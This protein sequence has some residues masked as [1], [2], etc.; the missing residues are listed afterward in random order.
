MLFNILLFF[1][2]SAFRVNEFRGKSEKYFHQVPEVS[3]R[4]SNYT[5]GFAKFDIEFIIKVLLAKNI[6]PRPLLIAL[7]ARTFPLILEFDIAPSMVPCGLQNI[8]NTCYLISILQILHITPG[9]RDA[10]SN[11]FRRRLMSQQPNRVLKAHIETMND[12]DVAIRRG[13]INVPSLAVE[14]AKSQFPRPQQHDAAEYLSFVLGEMTECSKI[15]TSKRSTTV[16]CERCPGSET[17]MPPNDG[18][19][20]VQLMDRQLSNSN[21]VADAVEMWH[22]ETNDYPTHIECNCVKSEKTE[23]HVFS[24]APDALAVAF[25]VVYAD[26]GGSKK[27]WDVEISEQ[28]FIEDTNDRY[29]LYAI[30]V[31]EDIGTAGGHYYAYVKKNK[32]WYKCNDSSVSFVSASETRA[33]FN[34]RHSPH[35]LF[36]AKDARQSVKEEPPRKKPKLRHS[37]VI[38]RSNVESETADEANKQETGITAMMSSLPSLPEPEAIATPDVT[39][40]NSQQQE[41]EEEEEEQ[42]EDQE[43][44]DDDDD[45]PMTFSQMSVSQPIL[46]DKNVEEDDFT[47][48]FSQMSFEQENRAKSSVLD[49]KTPNGQDVFTSSP[50]DMSKPKVIRNRKDGIGTK[51]DIDS[52][53]IVATD[54]SALD[55]GNRFTINLKSERSYPTRN[56]KM[57]K[58]CH[59][60]KEHKGV[61]HE[62]K[63]GKTDNGPIMMMFQLSNDKNNKKNRTICKRLR[64]NFIKKIL[65]PAMN[66]VFDINDTSRHGGRSRTFPT[67][68]C[69]IIFKED[70][71]AIAEAINKRMIAEMEA[72]EKLLNIRFPRFVM[73][74][75]GAIRKN[76][77]LASA[78]LKSRVTDLAHPGIK[79]VSI[80]RG[81]VMTPTDRGAVLADLK[82]ATKRFNLTESRTSTP[83]FISGF[84]H[85]WGKVERPED[86]KLVWFQMYDPTAHIFKNKINCCMFTYLLCRALT[87]GTSKEL[88][89]V[90]NETRNLIMAAE[91][92]FACI[93]LGYALRFEIVECFSSFAEFDDNYKDF[94]DF[95]RR[96]NDFLD[97]L[98]NDEL[99]VKFGEEE[100]QR[101]VELQGFSDIMKKLVKYADLGD[102]SERKLSQFVNLK[103]DQSITSTVPRYEDMLQLAIEWTKVMFFLEGSTS[104]QKRLHYELLKACLE[105]HTLGKSRTAKGTYKFKKTDAALVSCRDRFEPLLFT[106]RY[107]PRYAKLMLEV[108]KRMATYESDDWEERASVFLTLALSL[109][110]RVFQGVNR[111]AECPKPETAFR[112][113]CVQEAMIKG[114]RARIRGTVTP[115]QIVKSMLHPESEVGQMILSAVAIDYDVMYGIHFMLYLRKYVE[116]HFEVYPLC[117]INGQDRTKVT[118]QWAKVDNGGGDNCRAAHQKY[119]R[120][121]STGKFKKT[122]RNVNPSV[123]RPTQRSQ[124]VRSPTPILWPYSTVAVEVNEAENNENSKEEKEPVEKWIRRIPLIARLINGIL[125]YEELSEFLARIEFVRSVNVNI[126]LLQI[127][128]TVAELRKIMGTCKMVKKWKT[129]EYQREQKFIKRHTKEVIM[130]LE[131][132]QLHQY[133]DETVQNLSLDTWRRVCTVVEVPRSITQP[134]R[135]LEPL[136]QEEEDEHVMIFEPHIEQHI[137]EDV[138]LFEQHS[139]ED[140]T[141]LEQHISDQH[142]TLLERH[143]DERVY[144]DGFAPTR[145]RR[146]FNGAEDAEVVANAVAL[147][148]KYPRYGSLTICEMV[149]ENS[150]MLRENGRTKAGI[151]SALGRL[152][153]ESWEGD[154]N[155][156]LNGKMTRRE[157]VRRFK[158]R[159]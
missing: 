97:G 121:K 2:V 41:K 67:K 14:A 81:A 70:W 159:W 117:L 96:A 157:F 110:S 64:E 118:Y 84:G 148:E 29:S 111:E 18:Y 30:V 39:F 145:R 138:T 80:H 17:Q 142:T 156:L 46:E 89:N 114:S 100:F 4:I 11:E 119:P 79:C 98:I 47:T 48:S 15:F 61:W 158:K 31:H 55:I 153:T 133:D 23:N 113:A 71:P 25:P 74:E 126:Q 13:T 87:K 77:V 37:M 33:S 115:N 154:L 140:M 34:T 127:F 5:I 85:C 135:T 16:R 141:L 59:S 36:Y 12:M 28:I 152:C 90:R 86:K 45:L 107:L 66:D 54:I 58:T 40:G 19:L 3:D 63:L 6:C 65:Q 7:F 132:L 120:R 139:D 9:A 75:H 38:T 60:M 147:C 42:E 94:E 137:D 129:A 32:S 102:F 105:R 72:D 143:I 57:T 76:F 136:Q 104:K 103:Y 91:E 95:E 78:L 134:E 62:I 53:I 125:R 122:L 108:V 146:R 26:H 50:P 8:G 150:R 43:D 49:D 83:L 92:A 101:H 93:R 99:F 116:E 24:H 52:L 68:N 10:C 82:K 1:R 106:S 56:V 22:R 51:H 149:L 35:L 131:Y 155:R 123:H 88:K 27:T 151:K 112:V 109:Y 20:M 128:F 130:I 144:R 73:V 69:I 21:N 44:D 124:E